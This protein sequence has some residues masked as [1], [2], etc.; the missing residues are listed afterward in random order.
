[1]SMPQC[2]FCKTAVKTIEDIISKGISNKD[3]KSDLKYICK[4]LGIS[5]YTCQ[6]FINNE[7]DM[8]LQF[9]ENPAFICNLVQMCSGDEIKAEANEYRTMLTTNKISFDVGYEGSPT[10][11]MCK[12]AFET[13]R[14]MIDNADKNKIMKVLYKFCKKTDIMKDVCE[15]V[16]KNNTNEIIDVLTKN[17]SPKGICKQIGLCHKKKVSSKM[18]LSKSLLTFE[19]LLAIIQ[20]TL[21]DQ[22]N[23]D[24]LKLVWIYGY[25][26]T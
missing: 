22:H 8:V 10:C 6:D 25:L 3:I 24:H 13:V 15:K 7:V 26:K 5:K 9:V 11:S 4:K 14:H 16:V 18:L 17:I 21:F 1:M 19:F 20:K 23:N 12:S 2:L